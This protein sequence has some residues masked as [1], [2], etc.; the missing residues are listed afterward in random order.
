VSVSGLED[1]TQ[2]ERV[3]LTVTKLV[4]ALEIRYLKLE[5]SAEEGRGFNPHP[6]ERQSL[7]S[8]G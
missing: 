3:R 4:S 5:I 2:Q 6:N 7:T 8:S 1:L